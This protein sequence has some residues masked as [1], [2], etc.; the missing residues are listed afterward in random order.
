[1]GYGR[2][3]PRPPR[4]IL[5]SKQKVVYPRELEG[6]RGSEMIKANE[7]RIGNW[8]ERGGNGEHYQATPETISDLS[9]NRI[10]PKPI[11]LTKEWIDKYL[12]K[13]IQESVWYITDNVVIPIH[14]HDNTFSVCITYL[15]SLYMQQETII[16]IKYIHHL[17]NLYFAITGNELTI[18]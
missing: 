17:Q 1:M 13:N 10:E 14:S 5:F 8:I 2:P 4:K 11:P 12:T 16:H 7:L 6:K 9:G 15:G 18:K 3:T